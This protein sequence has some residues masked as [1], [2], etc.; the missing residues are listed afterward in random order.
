MLLIPFLIAIFFV[1][2]SSMVRP[3]IRRRKE[4]RREDAN[5]WPGYR[6]AVVLPVVELLLAARH[7]TLLLR[8]SLGTAMTTRGRLPPSPSMAD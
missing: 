7:A 2:C 1:I 4:A 6:S 8:L 5:R 3:W